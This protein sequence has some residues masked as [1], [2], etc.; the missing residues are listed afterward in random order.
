M[1]SVKQFFQAQGSLI[2]LIMLGFVGPVLGQEEDGLEPKPVAT[3]L[4]PLDIHNR[5][6]L[7]IVEQLRHNH[8]VKKELNDDASSQIF[9]KYIETL[10][11]GRAYFTAKDIGDF[12]AYRYQLDDA[13]KRGDLRPAF[14]IFNRYQSSVVGRFKFMVSEVNKGAGAIDFTISEKIEIDRE[15]LP[16]PNSDA[17]RDAVWKKRLKASVLALKLSGKSIEEINEQLL[18]RYKNQ[19]KQARQVKS[20]DAFQVYMNSFAKSYDPHTQYF[21]PRTSENFNINMSLSLEGIGAVLRNEEDQTSVVSLVPAGPADKEGTL[22]P[23]DR[24]ISVG[25]GKIGPL[26]DIVGWRLDDVVELIRGPKDSTVR[27]EII[28]SE[29]DVEITKIISIVRNTVRLEEQAAQAKILEIIKNDETHRIGVLDIPTFYIDFQGKQK[30]D[31]NYTST[32]RDV[33]KLIVRLKQENIDSLIIDLRGNGGGSLE[34]ARSL[35]GLF[36]DQGPTVQVKNARRRTTVLPD[37]DNEIFWDGPLTVLVNRLSAS[38]SEIFAGAMQDY[39]RALIVGN[40]TFGKG[41]VQTLIPLNRGQ[42]KLTAAKFY[43]ISGESTQH[44]GVLPDIQFP[45][46]YDTS[47]IGESSY[48]D[49]MPWDTIRPASYEVYARIEPLISK[50]RELHVARIWLNADFNYFKAIA[51]R[52]K[53]YSSRSHISLNEQERIQEKT[54]DDTWRL[55]LENT[56]RKAKG[57]AIAKD[58]DNLEELEKQESKKKKSESEEITKSEDQEIKKID[59]DPLI[60]ETGF[61]LLDFVE[62][63]NTAVSSN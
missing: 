12:E 41:T 53:T 47:E 33:K 17:E 26:I 48:D 3:L 6:N 35:T 31:P 39:G 63:K 59:D 40:Q 61:I 16:W 10:D 9:E 29:S 37:Q 22:E 45:E 54:K 21:S 2:F 1:R 38:A 14:E 51:D 62:L 44:Q 52:N 15:A 24:I 57:K 20:E 56:L 13:L 36:I 49:A 46:L 19:L 55:N 4:E 58:L 60:E 23:T 11:R 28:Q 27:L 8:Y 42:L 34:E 32:T 7:T 50:I 5:T 43:R 30:G 18:K 25:Q